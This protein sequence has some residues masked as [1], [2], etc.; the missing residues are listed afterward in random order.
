MG[1][2]Y[3]IDTATKGLAVISFNEARLEVKT[4]SDVYSELEGIFNQGATITLWQCKSLTIFP[5]NLV[6]LSRRAVT[7]THPNCQL[8]VVQELKGDLKAIANVAVKFL[9]LVKVRVDH[10]Y[11]SDNDFHSKEIIAQFEKG[12]IVA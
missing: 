1:T 9:R 10:V 3:Q 11:F 2:A 8:V 12:K 4:L 6:S 7:L 5:P